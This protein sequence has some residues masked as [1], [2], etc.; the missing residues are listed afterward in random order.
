MIFKLTDI[1]VILL[2]TTFVNC[3]SA[4]ISWQRRK[5]RGGLLFALG[6]VAATFW[7]LASG[8]DYAAVPVPLKVFFAQWE[9]VGSQSALAFFTMFTLSYAGHQ[10]WLKKNRSALVLPVRPALKHPAGMGQWTA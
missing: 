5:S 4:L 3:F 1:S 2:F 7:T 8:F 6:M 10:D 9:Y